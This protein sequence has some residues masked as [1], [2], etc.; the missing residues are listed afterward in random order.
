MAQ[1]ADLEEVDNTP[2]GDWSPAVGT[3][4]EARLEIYM[5][6]RAILGAIRKDQLDEQQMR[7]G[8]L[9]LR[10]ANRTL[11]AKV[12]KAQQ[13]EADIKL[14]NEL[15]AKLAEVAE[16]PEYKDKSEV[17]QLRIAGQLVPE[18]K[19][20]PTFGEMMVRFSSSER[21]QAL[22][23]QNDALLEAEKQTEEDRAD[24]RIR[25]SKWVRGNALLQKEPDVL[26]PD[27][28][29][30]AGYK[31]WA[32]DSFSDPEVINPS[33]IFPKGGPQFL[34]SHVIAK[35]RARD[36]EG[37]MF[38]EARA[39]LDADLREA[40]AVKADTPEGKAKQKAMARVAWKGYINDINTLGSKDAIRSLDS[41]ARIDNAFDETQRKR[42]ATKLSQKGKEAQQRFKLLS[43][44]WRNLSSMAKDAMDDASAIPVDRTSGEK[45]WDTAITTIETKANQLARQLNYSFKGGK[46]GER[47]DLEKFKTAQGGNAYWS[48]VTR[49]KIKNGKLGEKP[50]ALV[51]HYRSFLLDALTEMAGDMDKLK[52]AFDEDGKVIDPDLLP[53]DWKDAPK[54][55]TVGNRNSGGGSPATDDEFN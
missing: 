42:D 48:E 40:Y 9:E 35:E 18:A 16:M 34:S 38:D 29:K 21:E 15:R 4:A 7:K 1:F 14:E 46:P 8:E 10:E 25:A 31:A 2:A 32:A 23:L 30:E 47:I 49:D 53:D 24:W 39:R 43:T 51:E 27:T 45:Q 22:R 41:D 13:E 12:A 5:R 55:G 26:G 37:A 20:L 11:G 44:E 36:G 3:S 50:A 19:A 33:I 28:E 6:E 17:E 54:A 52:K